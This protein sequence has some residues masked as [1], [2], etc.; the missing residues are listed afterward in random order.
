[1]ILGAAL[2]IVLIPVI[3]IRLRRAGRT[4]DAI[5]V[6]HHERMI[7]TVTAGPTRVQGRHRRHGRRPRT[8][9]I[10]AGYAMHRRM[11]A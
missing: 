6:E 10:H 9:R 4:L 8:V 11:S 3:V 2:L 5:M 7:G 1:M